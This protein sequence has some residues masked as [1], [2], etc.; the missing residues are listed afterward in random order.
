M[1]DGA[2]EN[3]E[4]WRPE[5]INGTCE[6]LLKEGVEVVISGADSLWAEVDVAVRTPRHF[7]CGHIKLI[8]AKGGGEMME[9]AIGEGIDDG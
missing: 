3:C 7:R 4:H 6:E 2:C 8:A 5:R 1:S 9:L